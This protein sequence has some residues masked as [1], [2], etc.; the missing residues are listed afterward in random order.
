MKPSLIFGVAGTLVS[1]L[2]LVTFLIATDRDP[3]LLITAL[4]TAVPLIAVLFGIRTIQK[5]TNGMNTE[6]REK[7]N[8]ALAEISELRSATTPETARAI[9]SHTET[10]AVE[11]DL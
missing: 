7:Y 9:D 11:Y 8:K 5:Q 2:I 1:I 10:P 6:L 4:V 3:A